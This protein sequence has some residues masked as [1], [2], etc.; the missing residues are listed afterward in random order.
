MSTNEKDYLRT[1]QFPLLEEMRKAGADVSR[2]KAIRCPFHDDKHPSSSIYEDEKGI[3]RFKCFACDINYDVYDVQAKLSN[4]TPADI[5]RELKQDSPPVRKYL[6]PP[7]K[8]TPDEAKVYASIDEIRNSLSGVKG[9]YVYTNEDGIPLLYVF[10]V[11]DALGK[12][13]FQQASP[14]GSGFVRKSIGKPWP[15]YRRMEIQESETVVVVEGEKCADSLAAI[16]VEATTSP[17]GAGNAKDADWSPIAGKTV[18]LWPDNDPVDDKGVRKGIAHMKDVAAILEELNPPVNL[19]WIDCDDLGLPPK[20]DVVDFIE[21]NGGATI[22]SKRIA[23]TSVLETARGMG[24]AEE[25]RKHLESIISGARAVVEMPW[26][27]LSQVTNAMYPGAITLLCG[28]PGSTKSFFLLEALFHW[29]ANGVPCAVYEMEDD[30]EYHMLRHLAQAEYN[31]DFTNLDW[32]TRNPEEIDAA[33]KRHWTFLNSFGRCISDAPSSVVTLPELLLWIKRRA[34]QGSRI[35][36][37]DPITACPTKEP[38]VEDSDFLMKAKAI[39]REYGASL[40]LVTH[41]K[42]GSKAAGMGDLSGGA[43]YQRFAQT[44]LWIQAHEIAKLVTIET[45]N[46]CRKV[47]VNRTIRICKSR[48]SYGVSMNIGFHFDGGT[49]RSIEEGVIR[50]DDDGEELK[51]KQKSSKS[52]FSTNPSDF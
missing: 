11:I 51:L 9:E 20:G 46:G 47:K 4:R 38:W 21:K 17:C 16:G 42:K 3:W 31:S 5:L 1:D 41:P 49:F 34:A 23:V 14:H 26:N 30:R 28:D 45:F 44:I 12:K 48:N 19:F 10:R 37:I 24:P 50:T 25:L 15:I 39:I 2:P 40:I 13:T 7:V 8:K 36:A 22:E 18:Y 35:I 52:A 6:P 32:I 43:A 33:M 29:H 27:I